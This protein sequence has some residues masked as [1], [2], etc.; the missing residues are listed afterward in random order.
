MRKQTIIGYC[1]T[2]KLHLIKES[3]AKK[4]NKIHIAF[5]LIEEGE[6]TWKRETSLINHNTR[7]ELLRLKTINPNVKLILS[8]GGWDAD[9]FSQGAATK[10]TRVTLVKSAIKIVEEEKLDGLDIDWEY[11]C[12]TE[13]AIAYA[14]E[15][16]ENF[17][18]LL[19]EFRKQLDQCKEYKSLS[20]A[21]G[22]TRDYLNSTDMKRVEQY[23]DYIQL[24]TYD[25]RTGY[26][27]KT[28]H[29]ANLYGSQ[30]EPEAINTHD[31]IQL[32]VE[33]GVPINKLVMGAAFY[34]REWFQVPNVNNGLGIM[35]NATKT[36]E[37][38][39]SDIEKSLENQSEGFKR[40]WDED[41]KAVH[42]YNQDSFITYEDKDALA[43]KIN[44]VRENNM[45]GIM[46]WEYSQDESR[47]LIEYL[48]EK[49]HK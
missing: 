5:G 30:A 42:L 37:R 10:E 26:Q 29:H 11:P 38:K 14:P 46:F 16:K 41:A 34:G 6:V 23:L 32:F 40:Y 36:G 49:L 3:D 48:Y 15:D 27:H 18:L 22:V 17:T 43:Y 1:I 47:V 19:K 7:E 44:Y 21:A 8:I 33:L 20:I 9:G 28:G 12:I 4:L 31:M 35:S 25:Y 2:S 13:A 39:Y 24:M 45:Y